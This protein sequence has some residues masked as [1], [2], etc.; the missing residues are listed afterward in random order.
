MT[1]CDITSRESSSSSAN[2]LSVL[3]AWIEQYQDKPVSDDDKKRILAAVSQKHIIAPKTSRKILIFSGSA[4]FRHSSIPV[5]KYALAEL[6]LAS[7]AYEAV[8]S[9][10]PKNFEIDTLNTFDAVVLLNSTGQFFMPTDR[11]N[12]SYRKDFS[13][14]QWKAFQERHNRLIDNLY[15][16]VV[17]GGGLVG[18]HA[19]TDA[20]YGN[21]KYGEMM[22]GYFYGHP[23]SANHS[24]TINVEDKSHALNQTIFQEIKQ[25]SLKEEIYQF[26]P[27]PY[28][29]EKLR[30]LLNLNVERSDKPF[31]PM[32]RQ[33]NDYAIAWVNKVG[34][35]RVFYTSLGHRDEL[36][37]TPII[38]NHYLAGIQFATG[39]LIAD[40]TPSAKRIKQ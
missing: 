16:Y 40:T 20:C 17:A 35:G 5:G 4:G 27:K 12:F 36:Y 18:I 29:R 19:A 9:H 1:A 23:W 6:G 39:D 11:P 7:G 26:S 24:V 10:D 2:A 37:W 28:S 15:D 14:T 13:D 25:F 21:Q 38:L 8:V 3:P 33:D 34:K 22:G 31:K 32:R 30:V